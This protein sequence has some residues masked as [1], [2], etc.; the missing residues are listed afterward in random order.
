MKIFKILFLNKIDKVYLAPSVSKKGLYKDYLTILILKVFKVKRY[1]HLHNK[2]VSKRK[3]SKIL[4]LLYKS[5][6]KNA[7][8]VLLS[9]KL[10]DDVKDFV[11]K[12][13]VFICPNGIKDEY[14]FNKKE[15]KNIFNILFLSNLI[16]SKGVF[17][18]L[19]ACKILKDKNINFLCNF[20]GG[21]GDISKEIFNLK[22]QELNL[23]NNVTYLGR[24]YN[25]EKKEIF[26]NSD[27]FVFPTFYHNE[28]FGLVNVEA[29]MYSLPVISTDEG[30]ISDII[31]DGKTG[32]IIEKKNSKVLAKKIELLSKDH[33]LRKML[34][35]NGRKRFEDKFCFEI[36]EE[37]MIEILSY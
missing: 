22:V 11:K 21:E 5:F 25:N 30:G 17:I 12:D 23:Q 10:Y 2:G 15:N 13:D 7:K 28:T 31:E 18:L 26:L 16:E 9:E 35:E 20:V 4:D 32:Y 1:Y 8:V 6:F 27:V 29:M 34:G 3:K 14:N 33:Q 37:K 36:F 19:E 24:K